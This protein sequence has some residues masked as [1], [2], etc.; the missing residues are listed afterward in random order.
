M[1]VKIQYI[2]EH[3]IQKKLGTSFFNILVT[4][5]TT[6]LR[7]CGICPEQPGRAGTRR[8]IH[9]LTSIVVINHPLYASSIFTIHGILLV[10][11]T[12]LTDFSTISVQVFFGLPL[13]LAPST[14]Y[15]KC[16]VDL[17]LRCCNGTVS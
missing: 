10:Q 8:N 12:C 7:L 14:S 6:I 3:G 15:H 9:P 2:V 16:R 11:F 5:T 13:R 4:E 17:C 1:H